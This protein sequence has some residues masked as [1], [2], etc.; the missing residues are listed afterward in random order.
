MLARQ[1]AFVSSF[2]LLAVAVHCVSNEFARGPIRAVLSPPLQHYQKISLLERRTNFSSSSVTKSPP[3]FP[4]LFGG[5]NAIP[6]HTQSVT[7]A[8][9][10]RGTS[11]LSSA[12]AVEDVHVEP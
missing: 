7:F 9:Q 4:S 12:H 3:V 5:C 11:L 2:K 10:C 8:K 6:V 1:L